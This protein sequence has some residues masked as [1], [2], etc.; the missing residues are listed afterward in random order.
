MKRAILIAALM[1][2]VPMFLRA[3]QEQPEEPNSA[4]GRISMIRGEVSVQRGD[5]GE[6]VAATLNTPLVPGD[7]IATGDRSRAEVQLDYAN[8]LRLDQRADVMVADLTQNHIQVQLASGLANLTV[9][10]GTQADVEVDTPNMALHPHGEGIYR[11]QANSPSDTAVT[12]RRG[13]ADVSTSQGS[14]TVADGQVIFVKG[15][16]NPEYR[17][18]QAAPTDEWDQW[19]LDRDR[20]IEQA[21]SYRYTNRYYTGAQDLDTYG[22]WED[23][24]D[25][26]YCWTPYGVDA[27]WAPYRDGRWLWEP[28][29]GWT[30]T[31]Y[32]PWGWAPYHYGRWFMYGNSWCWWPGYVTPFYHPIWAPAYVNFF[33]FGFGGRNWGFGFGFGFG[34]IG[35]LPLGPV[36][37]FHPWWGRGY[38]SFNAVNITN[39][40]NITN[41]NNAHMPSLVGPRGRVYASNLQGAFVNGRIRGGI[42]TVSAQNF[43]NG[44]IPRNVR[45][46]DTNTLRQASLVNGTLPVAPTRQSLQPINRP[47][48]RASLPAASASTQRFF[49]SRPT[50]AAPRPFSESAGGIEQMMRTH[51]SLAA[52]SPENARGPA[53]GGT[54]MTARSVGQARVGGQAPGAQAFGRAPGSMAR[55][56]PS[57]NA[58]GGWRQFSSQPGP[59]FGSR[60]P[61]AAT[62]RSESASPGWNRFTPRSSGSA[63]ERSGGWGQAA[64]RPY[65]S[66]PAPQGGYGNW[67]RQPLQLRRPIVPD[68]PSY[69]RSS[70][71]SFGSRPAPSGG[72]RG[73]SAPSGG[74]R[75]SSAPSGGGSHGGSSSHS[76]GSSHG[77]GRH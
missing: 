26:G 34:S 14:T 24:P 49:A 40:T 62:P 48:N 46:L 23:V 41:G 5:S 74:G 13:E 57:Q 66:R 73:S 72:G 43:A 3:Q 18:A 12:V 6:W 64:P 16:D 51:T 56:A 77:G 53:G 20:T 61:A 11:I 52:T 17:I 33:G 37:G 50:P 63:P 27:S 47:V 58:Q 2:S 55:P 19:N 21:N 68:R 8:I 4:V 36:D 75:G 60:G 69:P 9:L 7:R 29:W 59:A 54:G 28:Y 35:W 45:P 10:N 38:N 70:G 42:T 67:G 31:S 1:I 65:Y 15:S 22:Q 44:Q 32:E 76:G 25:Y 39:V 30:W 71:G